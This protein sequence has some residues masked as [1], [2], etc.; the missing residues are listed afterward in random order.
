MKKVQLPMVEF[1][2]CEKELKKTRLTK[3]FHLHRSFI[4]AGGQAGID[5]VPIK[6]HYLKN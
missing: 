4:C 5:T 1:G 3:K 2:F 6:F